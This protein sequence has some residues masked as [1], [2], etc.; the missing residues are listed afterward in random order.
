EV[1]KARGQVRRVANRGVVHP[2]IVAD[3][4]D[5]YEPRV[6][7][8]AEDEHA[9]LDVGLLP[10]A[11]PENAVDGERREDGTAR[12]ILV[13]KGCPEQGHEPVSEE[14]VDRALV[15]VDLCQRKLKEPA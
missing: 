4:A 2:K 11:L 6:Q 14:L 10:L 15:A 5:D 8:H 13:R 9:R 3:C 1:L 7:S 12:M